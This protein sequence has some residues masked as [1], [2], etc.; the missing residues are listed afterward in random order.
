M[1]ILITGSSG[2]IGYHCSKKLLK[3]GINIFG[4]DSMNEYYSKEL[5]EKR[6][7]NLLKYDNF[8]FYEGHL[9]DEKFMQDVFKN[10]YTHVINL[11][12]QAGVRY[13]LTNP[14]AYLSSNIEGFL[15]L[16]ESIKK[17]DTIQHTLY[18]SSSSVY[19]L[20]QETIF[21][22]EDSVDH[23]VSLYAATKRSNELMA[24]VYSSMYGMPMT[25]LR[26]FTVY[27]PWG[28]P[29]MALFHFTKSILEGKS[30]EI[31]NHGDM[32]RDFTYVDDIVEGIVRLIHKIPIESP[33][34]QLKPNSSIAP[35]AIYNIGNGKPVK[36]MEFVSSLEDKLNTKAKLI[37]KPL[38]S[39]DVPKTFANNENLFDAINY[40]PRVSIEEGI[41]KFVD[42]YKEY[43]NI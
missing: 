11:A 2:F 37:M 9:E 41:S 24:H 38:Q 42:W 8:K 4:L 23:P 25:G 31:Y 33:V 7:E 5:K 39:G 43:Y 3:E 35:Y 14:K 26:F 18:A 22:E 30:I 6:L 19:G 21:S 27:G 36:L 20:N 34:S 16:L 28:R 12:A 1:K 10:K 17:Q 40:R 29:D 15:N 32:E 13:S